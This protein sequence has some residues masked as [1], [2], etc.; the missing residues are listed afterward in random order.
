MG[1]ERFVL[2]ALIL[3]G[4]CASPSILVF[5]LAAYRFVLQVFDIA[6]DENSFNLP[7][8]RL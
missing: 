6:V 4:F 2:G 7:L 1:I 5:T 8:I 3:A